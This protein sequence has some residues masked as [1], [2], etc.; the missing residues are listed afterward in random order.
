MQS[1]QRLTDQEFRTLFTLLYR[2]VM[3]EMDQFE[4]WKFDTVYGKIYV[5]MGM[6]SSGADEHYIDVTHLIDQTQ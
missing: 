2:Y 4:L 3:T 6:V 5:D 1:H